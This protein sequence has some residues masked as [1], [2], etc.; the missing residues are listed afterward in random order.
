TRSSVVLAR[1][2]QMRTVRFL[3]QQWQQGAERRFYVTNHADIDRGAASDLLG[4]YI[5]LGNADAASLRIELAIRKVG[6]EH[7]QDIAIEHPIVAGREADQPGHADIVGVVPLDIF[8]AAQS[9]HHRR[10][11]ALAECQ[12]L[13]MR[14]GTARATQ[15]RDAAVAVQQRR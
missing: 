2:R 9:M 4:P 3:L 6:P 11:E 14:A 12:K 1:L 8:L 5:D 15:N 10:F 7:E 13:V